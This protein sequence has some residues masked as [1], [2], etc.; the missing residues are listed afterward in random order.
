MSHEHIIAVTSPQDEQRHLSRRAS[1]RTDRDRANR[2]DQL[3]VD[4]KFNFEFWA[5]LYAQRPVGYY[6][7]RM[8]A[9]AQILWYCGY[10]AEEFLKS[11]DEKEVCERI[12]EQP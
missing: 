4:A 11:L 10:R 12:G 8:D 2:F 3:M 6:E 1:D 7:G 9:Y 5:K